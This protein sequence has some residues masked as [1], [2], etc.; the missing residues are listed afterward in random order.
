MTREA[1]DLAGRARLQADPSA[2]LEARVRKHLDA[3]VAE[4]LRRVPASPSGVDFCSNDYL[5]LARHPLLTERFAAAATLEGCGSTGSRLLRG[6]REVF[7]ALERRFA[8]FK[9]T[10]RSLY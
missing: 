7:Q 8:G 2:A 1:D 10:E 4:G 9:G 3:L 5:D 6:E